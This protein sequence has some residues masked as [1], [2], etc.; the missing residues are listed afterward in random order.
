MKPWSPGD[1]VAGGE[2]YLPTETLR[3]AYYA[4]C[5]H[6]ILEA[7]AVAVMNAP[8]LATRRAIIARYPA[9]WRDLLKDRVKELWEAGR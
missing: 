6:Q 2:V 5:Q 9:K 7:T 4:E 8:E 3:Q 1:P